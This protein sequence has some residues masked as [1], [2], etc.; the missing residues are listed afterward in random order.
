M[1][2]RRARI[3]EDLRGL[4]DGELWLEPVERAAYAQ[5]ASLF[6]IDPLGVVAPRTLED[7]NAVLRYAAG[8]GIPLH[9]RGAGTS[10]AGE[11]LGP[12]LVIDFSRH[13]RRIVEIRPDRVVVQPGVV[14]DTLNARLAPMGRRL[15]PDPARPEAVTIGGMIGGNAAGPRSLRLGTIADH[16]EELE[17]L[18]ANGE[19]ARLGR[20]SWPSTEETSAPSDFK[21]AVTR[22]LA[23]LLRWHSDRIARDWAR[24]GRAG[25]HLQRVAM[26]GGLQLPRLLCGSQGTLALVTEATLRTVPLPASQR[27]LL[28]P[29]ARL[30]DAA[31]AL[32]DCL[33]EGP[34]R[35]ELLDWRSIRLARDASPDWRGWL[36]AS[37]EAVLIVEFEGDD[38]A[39]VAG[40]VRALVRRL[41]QGS[42]TVGPVVEAAKRSDCERLL[43]LAKVVEPLMMR[44]KGPARPVPLLEG[45]VVPPEALPE[46][47]LRLQNIFKRQ[48]VNWTVHALAGHGQLC[49][50]PF[51]DLADPGDREKLAPLATELFEAALELGGTASGEH[52]R[53]LISPLVF[54]R[55]QGDLMP[56]FREIK[57]IFDPEGLLNPGKVVGDD[58]Q[59]VPWPL[60]AQ[61]PARGEGT[62][63]ESLIAATSQLRW[64]DRSPLEHATACN[65]C[66][67]C[68]S[69]EPS[70]RMCPSFRASR[71]EGA[72]PRAQAGLFRQLAAGLVDAKLWGTE[73]VK[74]AADQ[75][76]HCHLCAPECPAGVDISGLM[77]EAKAAYVEVH[78]LSPT[79]WVLSRVEFWSRLG[80]RFPILL[81]AL[82]SSRR[83]RWVVERLFGVSRLRTLPRA[84]R[85]P[86][87]RRAERLGLSRPRPQ[88]PGPRVAYF[89]DIV[90]N[91]YD[92][93]LAEAI[94]AVLRHCGVN[95]FVPKGQRGCGMPALMAGDLETAREQALANLRILGDAVRDGYTI[96]CSEPTAA[97]MLRHEYQRLTDDLDA[98][99]VAANTM[100]VGQY[101]AGLQAR[102]LLPRPRTPLR[103]RVGYHQPCHLRALGVG[104]PGL[105]LIRMIPE[106]EVEFID[107]GCSGIAG[108][109]GMARQN[110][111]PS[112]RAGRG[113]RSRL[114][115]PDIEMGSSE[116]GTCRMQMEQ[117]TTK[118]TFHPIK[119]L[120]LGYGLDPSLRLGFREP[121]PRH[122]VL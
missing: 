10:K 23:A 117:G 121:K 116:C 54:R 31:A 78:G 22:K 34:S 83:A 90:P 75:C 72:S 113:L 67:A 39:P 73:D 95:V 97:L 108:T 92:Q 52:G 87:V 2:E 101:L 56:V 85:T 91:Y 80:S 1:D 58:P 28:L 3:H 20:E 119:L 89:V 60:R 32:A 47:L 114:R 88:E 100:D 99:L 81:N 70:L 63:S 104:T 109:F 15:G 115:D 59:S 30:G 103:A 21:E 71:S 16:V 64:L 46:Y 86:F 118:R 76:V 4:L 57:N 98:G 50:R 61:A 69:L 94:V 29:F 106:L 8:A 84:R 48:E 111:R 42:A 45:L 105:D 11:V 110:F 65:G 5:D 66:G 107:R 24:V 6:E 82:M 9:P 93:E 112:L 51:L 17:V 43:G 13:F 96:V 33:R 68:R 62:A 27:V 77:L 122:Q 49:A 25:Y 37:A 102:G 74:R 14:L 18:F 36:S 12:G 79:D 7:L 19:L 41:S 53:G 40:R 120:G 26:P 38:P 44:L 55:G 35:C